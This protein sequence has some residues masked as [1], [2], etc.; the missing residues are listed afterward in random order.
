MLSVMK[1]CTWCG[2]LE[3]CDGQG[4]LREEMAFELRLKDEKEAAL[5]RGCSRKPGQHELEAGHKSVCL[6]HRR[7]PR[8]ATLQ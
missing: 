8:V 5:S 3:C 7:K 4:G 6:R 1:L 2:N